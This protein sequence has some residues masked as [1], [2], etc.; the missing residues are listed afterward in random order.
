GVRS[1]DSRTV[2]ASRPMHVLAV[3]DNTANLKLL[4]VLLDELGA[5][6][7]LASSGRQALDL[8]NRQRF[9]LIL[10]DIQMPELNGL[11]VTQLL[12]GGGSA[13][14]SSRIVAVT[15]HLLPE[16]QRQL[17]AAGFDLCLTKPITEEQLAGLLQHS[18]PPPSPLATV[19]A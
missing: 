3:D 10:M 6:P 14:R 13:N 11:Q 7:Q 5:I 9:D 8:C 2:A 19:D 4:S 18:D 17:L 16:E 1:D 15:A 12:R